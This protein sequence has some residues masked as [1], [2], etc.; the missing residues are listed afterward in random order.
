MNMTDKDLASREAKNDF[1]AAP[2]V[3]AVDILEDAD[4]I[5]VKADLPGVAKEGLSID[6]HGDTLTLTGAVDLGDTA[7]LK[8]VY[9]EVRSPQYKR[10]FVLSR[11]LDTDNVTATLAHGVLTLR[12]PKRERARPRRIDVQA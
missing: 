10:A 12:V 8:S 6:V 11:D 3:P 1:H 7:Q 5:T 4:G 2:L 9:A